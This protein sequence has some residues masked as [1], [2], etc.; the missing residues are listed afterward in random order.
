MC[1]LEYTK[2]LLAT[3]LLLVI[4]S[5]TSAQCERSTMGN[6][7]WFTPIPPGVH[8]LIA[9]GDSGT[10]VHVIQP[11]TTLHRTDTI[12]ASGIVVFDNLNSIYPVG[13]GNPAAGCVSNA[14]LHITSTEE[15]ALYAAS[16]GSSSGDMCIVFPTS[17]LGCNYITQTYITTQGVG[18]ID[19]QWNYSA[20]IGIAAPYDSTLVT[21]TSLD[22]GGYSASVMLQAGQSYHFRS[23]RYGTLSG[24][25]VTSNGKPFA[26]FQGN[27]I[28]FIPYNCPSGDQIF[29]QATPASQWGQRHIIVPPLLRIGGERV[30][31]TALENDCRVTLDGVS[32]DTLNGGQT[33]EVSVSSDRAHMLETS[34]PAYVGMYL[35]GASCSGEIG[36][37]SSVTIPPIEQGISHIHFLAQNSNSTHDHFLNIATRSNDTASMILDD[38]SIAHYFT[39]LDSTYSYARLVIDSGYHTLSCSSGRFMAIIYGLGNYESYATVAGMST[40][41]VSRLWINDDEV[42]DSS[43]LLYYCNGDSTRLAVTNND[44][45]AMPI[46]WIIDGQALPDSNSRVSIMLPTGEH[47]VMA[48]VDNGCDTLYGRLFYNADTVHQHVML[49]D[50]ITYTVD[51]LVLTDSGLY[52]IPQIDPGGCHYTLALQISLLASSSGEEEDSLCINSIYHW[53]GLTLNSP[54]I[55]LDTMTAAN[56]CDSVVTLTLYPIDKPDYTSQIDSLCF[57]SIYHWHGLTLNSSGI[58]IDTLIAANGCDSVVTLT[59]NPI[60]KPD[61]TLRIQ[62]DCRSGNYTIYTDLTTLGIPFSWETDDSVSTIDTLHIHPTESTHC[63]LNVEYRCPFRDTLALA[64]ISQIEA[65]M[66]VIPKIITTNHL[67]ADAYDITKDPHERQWFVDGILRTEQSQHITFT[68]SPDADSVHIDLVA[69]NDYCSDTARTTIPVSHSVLWAPNTFTPN[70]ESNNIFCIVSHQII[71]KELFIYNRFGLLVYQTTHPELGWDGTS[72]G[73]PCPQGAYTW[74]LRYSLIASPKQQQQAVGTLTLLR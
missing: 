26:M 13:Y 12:D 58:Y 71:Q 25:R 20:V 3:A 65:S 48:I 41:I 15:I 69:S 59:L 29:E 53:H 38:T 16:Y 70:Q 73:Q 33:L 5:A 22:G 61:Y 55:Y 67:Y 2:H 34:S 50:N 62:G 23:A 11:L 37:P 47:S 52:Y 46:T 10:V 72:H 27:E 35:K 42:P 74:L 44:S 39:T 17:A 14:T 24:V 4:H 19:N 18:T 36:D 8:S 49:C 1:K 30:L 60:G 21:L 57:N 28:V 32:V 56:G 45:I 6:D 64:P 68:A 7:F 40:R 31:V 54:G 9:S 51:S 66:N 43:E 63:I